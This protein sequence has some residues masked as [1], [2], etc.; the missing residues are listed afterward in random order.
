[1]VPSE[2]EICKQYQVIMKDFEHSQKELMIRIPDF[3]PEKQIEYF[4][5]LTTDLI[6]LEKY[7]DLFNLTLDCI[8]KVF[9]GYDKLSI[10]LPMI[11][12]PKE[13]DEWRKH[14][15]YIFINHNKPMPK[16]GM[17]LSTE[18]TYDYLMEYTESNVDYII[19][20]LND[21]FEEIHNLSRYKEVSMKY[22]LDHCKFYL[23]EIHQ[24]LRQNKI[25]HIF[26]G[27]ML[28]YP[29]IF[30]K[31]IKM[32][33]TEFCISLEHA[34]QSFKVVEEH[35]NNKGRYVGFLKKQLELTEYR[36]YYY[37]VTGRKP[38]NRY[39]K[40]RKKNDKAK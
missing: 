29:E 11:M 7:H 34:H 39:P 1:M 12:D 6:N 5:D 30:H 13:I 35:I 27:N 3:R 28:R 19:I 16:I 40:T 15:K 32:G 2:D 4:G 22:F 25:R 20:G 10:V 21:F 24:I 36:R 17:M 18:A 33:C 8:A 31:L 37:D 23:R 38:R 26:M 9:G 14:I